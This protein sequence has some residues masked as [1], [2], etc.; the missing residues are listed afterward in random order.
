MSAR[1]STHR[2]ARP[3][4]TYPPRAAPVATLLLSHGA[5][6][7]IDA[8]T[9][10]ALATRL[11]RQ[12]VTRRAARA[13]LAGGRPQ[14]RH[15]AAHP[16]RRSRR[17][18]Q[19]AA[20]PDP[21]GGRG[22]LRRRPVGGAVGLA[23]RRGRVSGAL[24]PAAPAGAAGEVPARGAAGRRRTHPRRAGRA[25]HAWAGPRS[26]P[27]TSSTSTRVVPGGDH[28]LRGPEAR[29]GSPGPT[30]WRSWWSPRW[31]GW[32]ASW[33]ARGNDVRRPTRS[34]RCDRSAGTSRPRA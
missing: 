17:G 11:P 7:G 6:G 25:R 23:A 15:P 3:G 4:W 14:G 9:S 33:S 2:T 1:A 29:P 18:G 20:G 30:R 26:S 32:C 10:Q 34:S 24:V 16:R 31:S 5:G 13:A 12:G 21:A 19:G 8:R 22:P 27:T 28:G